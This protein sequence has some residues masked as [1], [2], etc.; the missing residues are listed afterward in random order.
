M[1]I[2]SGPKEE[3]VDDDA[4]KLTPEEEAALQLGLERVAEDK[5]KALLEPGPNWKQWF[6]YQGMK[7]WLPVLFLIVDSWI[8]ASWIG[9]DSFAAANVLGMVVSLVLAVYLEG[10][11]YLY[12]WREPSDQEAATGGRFRPGWRGLRE[13]GRWTPE[14]E[15]RRRWAASSPPSEP[16][17][18]EPRDFL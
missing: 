14:G 13:Y 18:P 2:R 15:R 8:A 17:A 3:P 6:F 10:L 1:L 4:N 12:L 9:N 7:W 11:A 16:G 5:R